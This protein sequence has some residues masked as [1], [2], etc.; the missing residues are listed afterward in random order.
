VVAPLI[1]PQEPA[2]VKLSFVWFAPEPRSVTEL[3]M[4]TW[5]LNVYV[6]GFKKT[7]PLLQALMALL[8]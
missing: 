6:P 2:P 1:G 4:V 3:L 5:P 8:I 7:T